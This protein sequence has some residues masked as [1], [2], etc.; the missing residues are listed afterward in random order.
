MTIILCGCLF[1]GVLDANHHNN[2]GPGLGSAMIGVVIWSCIS[3]AS[4]IT[5]YVIS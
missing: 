2:G 4:F 3:L 1:A 5:W